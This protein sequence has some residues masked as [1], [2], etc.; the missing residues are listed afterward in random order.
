MSRK[1]VLYKCEECA[2]IV[3][4]WNISIS[5]FL[6][7]KSHSHNL[8]NLP[9][10]DKAQNAIGP[11]PNQAFWPEPP[12]PYSPPLSDTFAKWDLGATPQENTTII[13]DSF[14]T[15]NTSEKTSLF[16][17][18]TDYNA[19]KFTP[20]F[21]DNCYSELLKPFDGMNSVNFNWREWDLRENF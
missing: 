2:K 7:S 6:E 9:S 5:H 18:T 11:S 17:S 1:I 16:S 8:R 10:F 12:P 3:S 15:F 14:L 4:F 19:A 13:K 20:D 21:F